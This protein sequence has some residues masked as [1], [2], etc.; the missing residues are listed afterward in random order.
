MPT[1]SQSH[2]STYY[3]HS[4]VSHSSP[5]PLSVYEVFDPFVNNE[6]SSY[7]WIFVFLHTLW[8]RVSPWR[9]G[10][11][12][13]IVYLPSAMIKRICHHAQLPLPTKILFLTI[14]ISMYLY[15]GYVHMQVADC[16]G[17]KVLGFLKLEVTVVVICLTWDVS[18]G[19]PTQF[20]CKN[21]V[22]FNS[23]AI[24]PALFLI[25]IQHTLIYHQL[26]Q[27]H[28]WSWKMKLLW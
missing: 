7:N 6:E 8:D 20:L 28:G 21:N 26:L 4:H 24:S 17:Q 14:C 16:K 1:P 15:R 3:M 10:W 2:P 9:H 22:P 18:A 27:F 19:D 5:F 13:E 12:T 11:P 23:W 25:I